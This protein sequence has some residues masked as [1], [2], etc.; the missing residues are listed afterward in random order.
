MCLDGTSK[1]PHSFSLGGKSLSAS[2]LLNEDCY[3]PEDL[4]GEE[5]GAFN[6]WFKTLFDSNS[7]GIDDT[8]LR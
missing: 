8:I 4:T 3:L 1:L 6:S 2:H 5:V 7:E